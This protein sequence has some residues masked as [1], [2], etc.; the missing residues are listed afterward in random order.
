M[1]KKKKDE[2]K[3]QIPEL[4]EMVKPIL[5]EILYPSP[6]KGI[7][8]DFVG[9]KPIPDSWIVNEEGW[10]NLSK[11]KWA[12]V[13]VIINRETQLVELLTGYGTTI[14]LGAKMSTE[15][16]SQWEKDFNGGILE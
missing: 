11:I 6:P 13:G 10:L 8:T 16:L 9:P 5:N 7:P 4:L 3:K 12:I 15:F 2:L 14:I 1:T